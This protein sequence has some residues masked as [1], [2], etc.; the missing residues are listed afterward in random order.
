MVERLEHLRRLKRD[1][2]M[3]TL[4][5]RLLDSLGYS[6]SNRLNPHDFN[7]FIEKARNEKGATY[8]ALE[9]IIY[10]IEQ[11][12]Q[13]RSLRNKIS[14]NVFNLLTLP[15]HGFFYLK[16]KI[17]SFTGSK[18]AGCFSIF[19][20]WYGALIVAG[21][22]GNKYSVP[23]TKHIVNLVLLAQ[24]TAFFVKYK[25]II[26][27]NALDPDIN[28][29]FEKGEECHTSI[30]QKVKPGYDFMNQIKYHFKSKR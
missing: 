29:L 4:T 8:S 18:A 30:I 22:I 9:N 11:D 10:E 24:T 17:W 27:Y 23:N 5:D 12:K 13:P 28:P 14:D 15:I 20:S 3:Y 6:P 19:L 7:E 21:Y 16:D 25:N 26:K 2:R 1:V